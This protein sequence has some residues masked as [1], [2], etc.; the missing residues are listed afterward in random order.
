[1]LNDILL[2][3]FFA[4]PPVVAVIQ[5]RQ[6]VSTA[7]RALLFW[8]GALCTIFAAMM[9][10]PM[11]ACSGTIIS[12]YS[13]CIGSAGLAGLFNALQPIILLGAKLYILVGVPLAI[14]ALVIEWVSPKPT[15]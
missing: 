11:L 9:V 15:T 4:M 5:S 12:S 14:V 3:F 2:S 10:V 6:M 7:A 13:S 8:G 1:M